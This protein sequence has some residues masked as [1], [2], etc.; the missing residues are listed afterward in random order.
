MTTWVAK[1]LQHT[2]D[3]LMADSKQSRRSSDD[4]DALER[5]G[6]LLQI[7]IR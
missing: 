1:S 2:E 4:T 5:L 7:K 6:L 3:R